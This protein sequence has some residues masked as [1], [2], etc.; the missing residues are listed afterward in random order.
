MNILSHATY[1]T[2]RIGLSA[3]FGILSF[4]GLVGCNDHIFEAVETCQ[5]ESLNARTVRPEASALDILLVVDNSG[6]MSQEQAKLAAQFSR[7]SCPASG[8]GSLDD[9]A[10][11]AN[12]LCKPTRDVFEQQV[13]D[14]CGFIDVLN[15]YQ[16]DYRFGVITTDVS[17][18]DFASAVNNATFSAQK[19]CEE[20]D[21]VANGQGPAP[22]RGCLQSAASWGT[23]RFLTKDTATSQKFSDLMQQI[24][25]YGSPMEAGLEAARAFLDGEDSQCP[26]DKDLFL[27]DGSKLLLIYLTDEDDCSYDQ[28][29]MKEYVEQVVASKVSQG[30]TTGFEEFCISDAAG[31]TACFNY[32]NEPRLNCVDDSATANP[33]LPKGLDFTV[34]DVCYGQLNYLLTSVTEYGR[35]FNEYEDHEVQMAV[36]G[37]AGLNASGELVTDGGCVIDTNGQPSTNCVEAF[38]STSQ[39]GAREGQSSTDTPQQCTYTGGACRGLVLA[40]DLTTPGERC[41]LSDATTRYYNVMD[42]MNTP[43]IAGSICNQSFGQTLAEIAR[44]GAQFDFVKLREPPEN[45]NLMSVQ[46][47][48]TGDG[49][50][51]DV[52]R[53]QTAA[54][55]TSG[56]A[57]LEDQIT[58]QMYGVEYTPEPGGEIVVNAAPAG[59]NSSQECV[60]ILPGQTTT[61]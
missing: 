46:V 45:V 34:Q 48:R 36:I 37:G 41:C 44:A 15:A 31:G 42:L 32:P 57:L 16:V 9:A 30:M 53:C 5:T 55:C 43:G 7:A 18:C 19:G 33:P 51:V 24:G 40:N 26:A 60:G 20:V 8:V 58:V 49:E 29:R 21:F 13:R 28:D 17:K 38:G 4:G 27:R 25:I 3:I 59:L 23:D 1:F 54:G 52:P 14:N 10:C 39:V 11:A 61:P 47:S 22:Q 12:P 35:F 56:W 6:S 50:F 2:A